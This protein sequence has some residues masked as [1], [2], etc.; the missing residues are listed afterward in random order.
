MKAPGLIHKFR[1]RVDTWFA[2]MRRYRAWRPQYGKGLRLP[3][4]DLKHW[5]SMDIRELGRQFQKHRCRSRALESALSGQQLRNIAQWSPVIR[6]T[7][8]VSA[9]VLVFGC[10]ALLMWSDPL[11][12]LDAKTEEAE[13][14][15]IRFAQLAAQSMMATLYEQRVGEIEAQFGDLLEMIPAS[16]EAVQVLHQLS[17]AARES[18]LRL[19]W[20]KPA[21]E[22]PG[23]AY[24][25]LPVDVRLIGNY[26]AVGRFLDAVS[27]MKHLITVDVIL[28]AAD[29]APGQLVL[30]TQ[31]KA[32]RGDGARL[33]LG[34]QVRGASDAT[35]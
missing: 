26:H 17:Q 35:R 32:Y 2:A 4:A 13:V 11:R 34:Q 22:I 20:F 7:V 9:F 23:D 8:L 16:L 3:M 33:P 15:K 28:E 19:Q 5:L 31:V 25:V 6:W 18:G 29:A 24:V 14:L 12:R 27:R 21:P 1:V 10:A 30:A